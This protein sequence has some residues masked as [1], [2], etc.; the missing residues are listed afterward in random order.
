[1]ERRAAGRDHGSAGDGSMDSTP[2]EAA[3]GAEFDRLWLQMMMEHHQG[4]VQ[5]AQTE[6]GKGSSPEA[7]ALAQQIIDAQ[8]AE[9]TEMQAMLK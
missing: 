3:K 8:Q 9:I 7:K 5:M 4:A 2:L 6:R 1:M